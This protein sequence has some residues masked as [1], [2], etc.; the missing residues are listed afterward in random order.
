MTAGAQRACK[1]IEARPGLHYLADREKAA[2]GPILWL[3]MRY[4]RSDLALLGIS[5]SWPVWFLLISTLTALA[6]RKRLRITL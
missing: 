1:R 4:P 5:A 2:G 6:L 3:E